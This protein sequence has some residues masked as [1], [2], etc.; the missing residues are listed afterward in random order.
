MQILGLDDWCE[1]EHT[2]NTQAIDSIL[3]EITDYACEN[4]IINDTSASRDLLIQN[5]WAL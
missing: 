2:E 1:Q 4:G 5:S 3:D